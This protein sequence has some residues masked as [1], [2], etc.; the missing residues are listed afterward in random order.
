MRCVIQ[1]IRDGKVFVNGEVVGKAHHGLLILCGF[2]QEDTL[3]RIS[4][5]AQRIA[6]LRIFPDENGK[7]N[8]SLIDENGEALVVSNFTLYADCNHGTRPDFS[9]AAKSEISKPMYDFF[10]QEMKKYV[11]TETGIFGEHMEL[12]IYSDG[13]ITVIYDKI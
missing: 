6:K 13:P 1:R 5:A 4:S 11:H 3:E 7:L 12:D 8:K 2:T 10:V 9:K